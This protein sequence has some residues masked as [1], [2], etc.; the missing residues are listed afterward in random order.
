[1]YWMSKTDLATAG[2]AALASAPASIKVTDNYITVGSTN[3]LESYYYAYNIAEDSKGKLVLE[4]FE[5][6]KQAD[7]TWKLFRVSVEK[8]Y[9]ALSGIHA[10]TVT[11]SYDPEGT[12]LI[13]QSFT[14]K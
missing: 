8:R 14:W 12:I 3:F 13:S 11:Q 7:N 10:A 1:T 6:G 2:R 5:G 4:R 9:T